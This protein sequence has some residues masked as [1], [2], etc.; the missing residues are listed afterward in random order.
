MPCYLNGI[1]SQVPPTFTKNVKV[2]H[3]E[4]FVDYSISEKRFNPSSSAG[5]VAS[6]PMR[7]R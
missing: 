3:P 6:L 2:G 7:R 4:F 1:G 5:P